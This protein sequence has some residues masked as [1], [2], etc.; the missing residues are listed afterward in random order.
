[1]TVSVTGTTL[2]LDQLERVASSNEAVELAE[3][4][5]ERMQSGRDVVLRALDR[6]ELVYGLTTGVGVRKRTRVAGEEL[7]EFNRRLILEHRVGQGP[8]APEPVVRAQLLLLANAFARGTAGVR[9]VLLERVVEVLNHGPLPSV[10]L[11][12]SIGEADLPANADLAHGL[13]GGLELEAKEGLSLLNNNSFS[14]ALGALAFAGAERLLDSLD[15]AACL[16]LEAFAAN[17]TLLHPELARQ[18]P[19]PGLQQAVDRLR[20]LLDGSWLWGEGA[21]RNLQD[22][23]TFR[24]IPHVHGAARDAFAFAGRQLAVELNASQENPLVVVSEDRVI[25]QAN[26]DVLPLAAAL[27]FVRVALAPVLMCAAERTVK[28][29]QAPLTGLP[30]GL[31]AESGLAESALSEFGVPVQ[32]LA[33]EARLLAQPVS[34]ETVSTSHHEGIEDRFTL[35]PLGAR[36][37]AEMVTLGARVAAIELVVAAQAIDLR[38]GPQLGSGTG[39]VYGAIRALVPPTGRGEPPPQDL[40]PIV[41]LVTKGL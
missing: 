3:G 29:L 5:L 12:G 2:S 22:P 40:E 13:L 25:S 41:G 39:P 23:L 33:A 34:F 24:S 20:G 28:L 10:R 6:E 17:L 7:G 14:T 26:F 30:E 16:D 32:A 15:V 4:V 11:L 19:Y 1:V 35:A 21:A 31:A 36:R 37:L 18:R 9:P 38:G 8:P 27:D